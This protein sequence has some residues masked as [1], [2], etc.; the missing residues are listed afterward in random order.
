MNKR[1]KVRLVVSL[2]KRPVVTTE[3]K[4]STS[5][6]ST[7]SGRNNGYERS[8]TASKPSTQ[9]KRPSKSDDDDDI[10]TVN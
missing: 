9:P 10:I 7:G 2:G 3:S 1:K 8:T 6:P 4:P 5:S